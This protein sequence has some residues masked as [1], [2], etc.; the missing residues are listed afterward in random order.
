[1][2]IRRLRAGD[3]RLVGAL[4]D[5]FKDKSPSHAEASDL[6]TR[7]DVYVFAALDGGRLAGFAL[8]YELPRIDGDTMLF[9]YEIGVRESD[10][11]RGLG[12]ALVAELLSV[13]RERGVAKMWVETDESNEAAMALYRSTGAVRAD[14]GDHVV[15]SWCPPY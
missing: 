9:F 7:D 10:R 8:A 14:G 11:R 2:V 3:E 6:L 12:R 5:A 15:W 13:C 1:M 4:T